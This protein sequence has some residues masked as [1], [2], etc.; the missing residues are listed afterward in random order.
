MEERNEGEATFISLAMQLLDLSYANF[1]VMRQVLDLCEEAERATATEAT[2]V[3]QPES[4]EGYTDGTA[5]Q[6][7]NGAEADVA[8]EEGMVEVTISLSAAN[9]EFL[10]MLGAFASRGSTSEQID[11]L[12]SIVRAVDGDW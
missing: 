2:D 9:R 7:A 10:L 3:A 5:P 11:R 4:D 1:L 8:G 6:G 12:I